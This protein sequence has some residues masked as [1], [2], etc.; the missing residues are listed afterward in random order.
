MRTTVPEGAGILDV[1]RKL[2]LERIETCNSAV[3]FKGQKVRI[4]APNEID[5]WIGS[6]IITHV[7]IAK[8]ARGEAWISV[9]HMPKGIGVGSFL[10]VTW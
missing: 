2:D 7:E 4:S 10:V 8:D 3:F 6:P 5:N 1:V 9:D